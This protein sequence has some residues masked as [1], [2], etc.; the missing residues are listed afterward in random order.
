MCLNAGGQRRL[1]A[2]SETLIPTIGGGFDV[3]HS[4]RG[5]G[6]DARQSEVL[7]YGNMTGPLDTD[8]HSIGVC[9]G[10]DCFNGTLTGQVAAT[11]GA[12][13]GQSANHAGPSVLQPLPLDPYLGG[14]VT[15]AIDA[16]YAKGCGGTSVAERPV[17]AQSM[18]VRRL[19]P[20]E[21]ERLQ[22]FP[23]GYT[24]I[25]WRG[26]TASECPDGPRYKALGNSWAV[27]VV[28]WIGRRINERIGNE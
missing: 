22:G 28:R 13:S 11:L 26:K 3:A 21:C 9:V 23:D 4:L 17:V 20:T 7:Q 19:T 16:S 1:D 25:P 2:E 18:Q 24:A 27:P 15:I 10:A 5:E 6:F 14:E 12:N 8:G